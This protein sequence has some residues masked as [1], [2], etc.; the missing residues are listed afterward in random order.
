MFLNLLT[1]DEKTAFLALA[2]KLIITDREI[3]KNEVILLR[4]MKKEMEI[5]ED[6][7]DHDMSEEEMDAFTLD[8][9]HLCSKFTSRKSKISALMELIGL[10]YVDGHFVANEKDLIYDIAHHLGISKEETDSYIDWAGRI[11]TGK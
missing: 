9:P 2:K 11:Y 5:L 7:L 10:G 3:S 6:L 4:S 1:P 8:I